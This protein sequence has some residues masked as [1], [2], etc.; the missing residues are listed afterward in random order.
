MDKFAESSIEYIKNV[1]IIFNEKMFKNSG[2]WEDMQ[3]LPFTPQ[4]TSGKHIRVRGFYDNQLIVV[5]TINDPSGWAYHT[6]FNLFMT[7]EEESYLN[8][9]LHP[10]CVNVV[11]KESG[12]DRLN[13]KL[14]CTWGNVPS[15]NQAKRDCNGLGMAILAGII[16]RSYPKKDVDE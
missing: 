16:S 7:P 15:I 10:K 6:Q 8:Q 1:S 9:E 5:S 2:L 12:Y 3:D 4:S 14:A 13:I 11:I